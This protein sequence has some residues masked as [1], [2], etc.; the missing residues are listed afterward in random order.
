M[1]G[2]QFIGSLDRLLKIIL[3]VAWLNFLWIIFSL[4]GVVVVGVFPATT[5]AIN[6]ARKWVQKK[7]V[8]SIYQL[9]KQTYKGEFIKSN[10]IGAILLFTA[11]ILFINYHALLQLG[12]QTPIIVVFAYYFVIFL[13]GIILI[14]I[15][16]L[17][18]HYQTTIMQYFKNAFIIGISKMPITI[19]I[20][21]AIFVIIY[22]SLELPTLL[23]FG[24]VSLIAVTV[25]FLTMRVFEKIDNA[26]T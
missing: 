15:F 9:F 1:F 12:D 10:I 8:K 23:L 26:D 16:P 14:W 11:V 7:E 20:G 6:V 3:Q 24:T 18:S 5:A 17:L 13:Y 2:E 21:F 4:L 25:A 22:F 19:A